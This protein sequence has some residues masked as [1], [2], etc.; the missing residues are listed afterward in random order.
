MLPLWHWRAGG[1]WD[2]SNRI[3]MRA[4]AVFWLGSGLDWVN[5]GRLAV[6]YRL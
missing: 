6:G 2:V 3:V 4:E 1:E 5:G